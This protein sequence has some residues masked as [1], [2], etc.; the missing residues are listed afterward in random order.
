[1]FGGPFNCVEHSATVYT[2][3]VDIAGFTAT[4]ALIYQC[5]RYHIPEDRNFQ[6]E[7]AKKKSWT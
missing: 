5:T 7:G 1:M 6:S 2:Q 4:L 3:K